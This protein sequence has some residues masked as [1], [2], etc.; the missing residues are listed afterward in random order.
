[1]KQA[2]AALYQAKGKGR[3][4][5]QI[6]ETTVNVPSFSIEKELRKACYQNQFELHYQPRV[7]ARTGRIIGA[8]AFLRWNHPKWG[9]VYPDAFISVAEMI[10]LIVPIGEWVLREVSRQ[11]VEW[12]N[13]GLE[14][15][16]ISIHLSAQ[17][18]LVRGFVS[19]LRSRDI[20]LYGHIVWKKDI[21]GHGVFQYGMEFTM[22][23]K[24]R[25][26]LARILNEFSLKLRNSPLVPNSRFVRM[27]SF[28]YLK[29]EG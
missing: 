4:T 28:N 13:Q 16:P 8:E 6:Y 18:F 9:L 1:M 27:N 29:R 10:G 25:S 20:Q 12:L 5:V 15:V 3:S 26:E 11:I 21:E 17:H 22:L 7:E 14:P 24:E 19:T 2:E 23:E